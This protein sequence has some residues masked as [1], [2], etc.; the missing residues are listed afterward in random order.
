WMFLDDR[1]AKRKPIYTTRQQCDDY[2]KRRTQAAQA[3]VDA[4]W[5]KKG[6]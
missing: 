4:Q 2:L 6:A 3:I 5:R 1:P